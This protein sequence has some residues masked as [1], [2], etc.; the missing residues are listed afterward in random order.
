MFFAHTM[1]NMHYPKY[2]FLFLFA[3]SHL[4]TLTIVQSVSS[5]SAHIYNDLMTIENNLQVCVHVCQK[6][7]WY[8]L[9]LP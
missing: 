9:F 2:I 1:R 3:F 4:V 6:Y 5:F 8:L 7:L